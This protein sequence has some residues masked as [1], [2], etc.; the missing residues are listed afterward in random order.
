MPSPTPPETV[1]H[2]QLAAG[3]TANHFCDFGGELAQEFV[4]RFQG[5]PVS[6]AC[7]PGASVPNVASAGGTVNGALGDSGFVQFSDYLI[8][9]DVIGF[10]GG[11]VADKVKH[12]VR[13]D[14]IASGNR[15]WVTRH[16][17]I[18]APDEIGN[19]SRVLFTAGSLPGSPGSTVVYSATSDD[20]QIILNSG[21]V[22]VP[23]LT[24][25]Q[26][27][28]MGGGTFYAGGVASPS[29]DLPNM[30]SFKFGRSVTYIMA[31]L[32]N[33]VPVIAP[34]WTATT[35]TPV[36]LDGTGSFDPDDSKAPGAGIVDL[37]WTVQDAGAEYH[38]AGAVV[39]FLWESP[40]T[41][42]VSLTA[43]DDEGERSTANQFV[44]VAD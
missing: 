18:T 19:C 9:D 2:V 33:P 13:A 27:Y 38:F 16:L 30:G 26:Y 4:T 17:F 42:S 15:V 41:Y 8:Q 37:Q 43:V 29:W 22:D 36:D 25:S 24:G 20:T 3:V 23:G 11:T 28:N 1:I 12:L 39:T 32:N 14:K 7:T 40:G 35:S 34:V 10:P 21:P 44:V 31:P 6:F 5:G